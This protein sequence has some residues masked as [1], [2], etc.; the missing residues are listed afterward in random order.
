MH[1]IIVIHDEN[2]D[3]AIKMN[4]SSLELF[5]TY[6]LEFSEVAEDGTR[7]TH[8]RFAIDEQIAEDIKKLSA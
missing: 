6:G 3:T 8:D 2:G 1:V 5:I 4:R 7:Y